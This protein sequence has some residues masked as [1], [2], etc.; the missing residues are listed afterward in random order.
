MHIIVVDHE[1]CMGC[2]ICEVVCS[3]G[4]EGEINPLRSRIGV[5]KWEEKGLSFPIEC[6]QCDDAPCAKVCPV[7]A[8]SRDENLNRVT[9]DYGRCIGCRSCVTVCPFGAMSF[10][11]SGGRVIKCDLCDGDPLCVKF[12]A[13]NALRYIDAGEMNIRNLRTAA[14]RL[15]KSTQKSMNDE[16]IR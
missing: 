9:V 16:K 10:D 5:V 11:N 2:R 8:I 13:Y 15:K 6:R 12:C 4:H 1:N 7:K 14:L 3:L